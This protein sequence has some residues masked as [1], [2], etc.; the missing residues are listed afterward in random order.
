[1]SRP[2]LAIVAG[3]LVGVFALASCG[4]DDDG[5]GGR[6][7]TATG[8][9]VTV[10]ARDIAFDVGRI[11]ATPGPLAVTLVEDGALPHTFV[12]DGVDDFKLEVDSGTDEDAGTVELDAGEYEFYCDVA[13]HRAQG[14]EG[15]L[16]VE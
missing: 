16:V 12:I 3:A 10:R 13:G 1:M 2:H 9:A 8:G 5:G 14:M 4:G 7:V 15:T 6:T 11:E